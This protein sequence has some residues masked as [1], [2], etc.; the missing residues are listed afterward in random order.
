M[1]GSLIESGPKTLQYDWFQ[2]HFFVGESDNLRRSS[3]VILFYAKI[4]LLLCA[5]SVF[6][7][8]C[9]LYSQLHV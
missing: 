8:T 4:H 2:R 1:T 6:P 5:L 9:I 7:C 3:G